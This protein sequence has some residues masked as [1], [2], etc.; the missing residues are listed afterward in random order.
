MNLE[1][2]L[3]IVAALVGL[4]A[5]WA[6][7]IDIGKWAGIVTD[8]NAGKWS[9]ALNLVSLIA[10]AISVNFFPN[11]NVPG[12]DTKIFEI[13][14]FGTLIFGYMIQIFG[15]K[16]TH[17]LVLSRVTAFSFTKQRQVALLNSPARK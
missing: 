14:K 9:A 8:T 6:L 13:V 10:V 16:L 1:T 15:S 5:L 3:L 11:L 2:V 12:V 4:P 17:K 7:L